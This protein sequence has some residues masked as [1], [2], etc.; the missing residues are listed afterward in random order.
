MA[1]RNLIS[2]ENVALGF[3][4]KPLFEDL[5]LHIQ[6]RDR[7]C[8]VGRNGA[9]KTTL[10]RLIIGELDLDKGSR[11]MLPGLKIGYLSQ[12]GRP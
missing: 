7:V 5:S 9:G 6:E 3:G 2:L 10:M 12:Q 1:D 4:G 8:L 11:F